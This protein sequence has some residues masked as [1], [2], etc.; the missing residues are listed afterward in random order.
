VNQLHPERS[1]SRDLCSIAVPLLCYLTVTL[2]L[3]LANG[4]GAGSG[5]AEHA[6]TTL[7]VCGLI[8]MGYAVFR[9]LR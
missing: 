5:F 8:A 1:R 6:F 7:L 4:A 9:I 2:G 3:P